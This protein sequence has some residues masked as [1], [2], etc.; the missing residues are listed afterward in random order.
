[1][2][3]DWTNKRVVEYTAWHTDPTE[4]FYIL[5]YK[6]LQKREPKNDRGGEEGLINKSVK[7]P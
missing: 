3:N 2:K 6:V 5:E 1:M 4:I 7:K